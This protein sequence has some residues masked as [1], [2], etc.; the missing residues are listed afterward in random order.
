MTPNP[1]R[2]A[3]SHESVHAPP[4]VNPDGLVDPN[5]LRGH[6]MVDNVA[7][8]TRSR[9]AEPGVGL[10]ANGRTVLTYAQLR[11]A[12]PAEDSRAPQH[13]IELHLTG[14]MQRWTWGFDGRKFSEAPPVQGPFGKRIRF[15]LIN[16]TMM[17]HPMH[18]HGFLLEL[19]N[20]QGDH[21]PLKHTILVK[22]AERL[23]FLWTAHTRGHWAFH[24]HLLYHMEAGMFRTVVVS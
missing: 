1:S 4:A 13:Q 17:E 18:L 6:P 15:T 7:M 19:E 8:Q 10:R 20:A 11:S 24:C 2:A 14:N 21:L 16:D 12:A 9:L 5:A 22:P 23:S 3:P